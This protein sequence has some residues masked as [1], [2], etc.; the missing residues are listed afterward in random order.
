MVILFAITVIL[1]LVI[2]PPSKRQIL[3]KIE[4][5]NLKYLEF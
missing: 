4:I 1:N 2:V 3:R 5:F